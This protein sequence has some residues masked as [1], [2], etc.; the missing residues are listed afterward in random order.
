ML[1]ISLR[2][3]LLGSYPNIKYI[4]A[5]Q[6]VRWVIP[7]NCSL[8]HFCYQL[9]FEKRDRLCSPV[10]PGCFAASDFSSLAQCC[11]VWP[12]GVRP[13]PWSH[14][15]VSLRGV[16]EMRDGGHSIVQGVSQVPRDMHVFNYCALA[17]HSQVTEAWRDLI[18]SLQYDSKV[19]CTSEDQILPWYKCHINVFYILYIFSL[20]SF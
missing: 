12:P 4:R 9:W 13:S 18:W 1:I 14:F 15:G 2:M 8:I 20:N 19:Y 17:R 6:S 11:L 7:S 5:S 10:S 3:G 16:E